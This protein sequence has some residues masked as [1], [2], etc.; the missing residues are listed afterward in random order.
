MIFADTDKMNLRIFWLIFVL[1]FTPSASALEYLRFT[2]NDKERSE[3][4]RIVEETEGLLLFESREGQYFFIRPKDILSR[5]SDETPF[6]YYTKAEMLDRL[7][8]EFPASEG[9]YYLDTHDPFI[10]VYT[11]SK[12]FATWYANLLKKLYEQYAV[13][14]KRL[15]VGLTDPKFPMVA[16]VLSNEERYRQYA[17]KQDG[18]TLTKECAYYNKLTNRIVLYDMSGLQTFQEGNQRRVN[19]MDIQQFLRQPGSYYNI[20]TVIHEAV[21]QVGYNTGMH[22]RFAPIPLWLLEGFATLHE[23][24]DT[25]NSVGWTLGQPH[26]NRPRLNQLRRYW[27]DSRLD[28]PVQK[29]LKE[30]T[31]LKQSDTVLDHY[32]LAWGL[33]YYLVKK[34]PKELAVYLEMMQKKKIFSDDSDEI[35]IK[36]FESCFGNDWNAFYKDFTNYMRRL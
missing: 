28:S 32:A 26:L 9:Y 18:V 16:V 13:H 30:D 2:H 14:W 8:E 21:H 1:A 6:V 31:L 36:D 25:R 34:R 22:P 24:P 15:G 5:R 7:K 19:A 29:M 11:T 12:P 3:E 33:T 10:V 27:E 35:R 4:G 23:V 20:M 17:T